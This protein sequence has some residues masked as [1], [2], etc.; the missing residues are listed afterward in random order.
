MKCTYRILAAAPTAELEPI[1]NS[2]K[3]TDEVHLIPLMICLHVNTQEDMGLTYDELSD[4]GRL[5]KNQLC[6]PYNM[7]I[8]LLNLWKNK[9]TPFEVSTCCQL[10][11]IFC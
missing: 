5:R 7:F 8:K 10:Y 11:C 2:H 4:I 6:G 3:Q 9:Y 1:T